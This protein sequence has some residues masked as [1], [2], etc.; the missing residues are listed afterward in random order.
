MEDDDRI[1]TPENRRELTAAVRLLAH[2]SRGQAWGGDA[3]ALAAEI[4]P[5]NGRQIGRRMAARLQR[6]PGTAGRPGA[7]DDAQRPNFPPLQRGPN[8]PQD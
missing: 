8:Q 2:L 6:G 1:T 3:S 4:V 7:A 5:P